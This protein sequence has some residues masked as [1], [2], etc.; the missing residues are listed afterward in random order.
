M[1]RCPDSVRGQKTTKQSWNMKSLGRW[2]GNKIG[3]NSYLFLT[4]IAD[5]LPH[6]LFWLSGVLLD[7]RLATS[8]CSESPL[9]ISAVLSQKLLPEERRAG[10]RANKRGDPTARRRLCNS[11]FPSPWTYVIMINMVFFCKGAIC[12]EEFTKQKNGVGQWKPDT[13]CLSLDFFICFYHCRHT[14]M[15]YSL[16][17]GRKQACF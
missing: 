10:A 17:L 16:Y 1:S 15:G 13:Q 7:L 4:T 14:S 9:C 3:K 5:A 2:N 11:L 8:F 6:L 12:S